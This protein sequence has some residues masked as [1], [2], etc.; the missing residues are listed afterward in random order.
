MNLIS[1]IKPTTSIVFG[2]IGIIIAFLS[3][4]YY[5]GAFSVQQNVEV[6]KPDYTSIVYRSFRIAPL[7]PLFFDNDSVNDV[8]EAQYQKDLAEY[9]KR[10]DLEDREFTRPYKL[11]TRYQRETIVDYGTAKEIDSLKCLRIAEIKRKVF[12]RD[13]IAEVQDNEL[14]Q[15]NKSCPNN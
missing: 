15:L 14:E 1:R 5:E 3:G 2:I 13:S 9:N 12:V 6:N 8:L 11:T 10:C 4:K 7:P